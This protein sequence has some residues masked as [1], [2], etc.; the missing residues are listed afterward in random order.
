MLGKRKYESAKCELRYSMA[1]PVELRQLVR[2]V[3][4]VITEPGMRGKGHG[5]KLMQAIA[6]EADKCGKTLILI[7]DNEKLELWYN[8]FGFI[9]VQQE[10]KPLMLREPKEK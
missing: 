2:E 10:P 9:K 1:L 7:P 3:F 4:N 8:K 5:S 6:D